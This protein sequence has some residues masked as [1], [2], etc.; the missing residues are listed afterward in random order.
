MQ[1]ISWRFSKGFPF[2]YIDYSEPAVL[3][4]IILVPEKDP[5]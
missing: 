5:V 3:F 4:S 2:Y 1:F